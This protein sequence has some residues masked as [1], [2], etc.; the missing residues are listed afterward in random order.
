VEPE[1]AHPYWNAYK[2]ATKEVNK[3]IACLKLTIISNFNHGSFVSGD[4]MYT[5]RE[6]FGQWLR[7]KDHDYF[8]DIAE[9]IAMD[10]EENINQ[11]TAILYMNDFMESPAIAKRLEFESWLGHPYQNG[12][13]IYVCP[14]K[15]GV[16]FCFVG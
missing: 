6:V 2:G 9:E 10:R 1:L 15:S 16:L 4:R 7:G 11:D 3:T 5:K 8:A 13:V 14:T 12:C